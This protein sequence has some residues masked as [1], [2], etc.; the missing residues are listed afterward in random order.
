MK[1]MTIPADVKEGK[2][3][4]PAEWC[5][6]QLMKQRSSFLPVLPLLMH[7]VEIALTMPISNAWPERGASRVKL[8]KTKPEVG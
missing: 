3:I 7:I 1:E 5:M 2:T 8:I 6:S 4:M